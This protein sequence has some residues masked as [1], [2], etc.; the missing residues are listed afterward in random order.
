MSELWTH[1]LTKTPFCVI[2]SF[3]FFLGAVIFRVLSYMFILK[4][5]RVMG[6]TMYFGLYGDALNWENTGQG[7][8]SDDFFIDS[9]LCLFHSLTIV[10][11]CIAPEWEY[12][13]ATQRKLW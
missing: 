6:E 7:R 4:E 1:A 11:E 2:F 10:K 3:P 12:S 9:K 5:C 8:G 13:K